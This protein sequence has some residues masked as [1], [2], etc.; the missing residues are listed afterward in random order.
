[1][2]TRLML[3]LGVI[4]LM[5]LAACQSSAKPDPPTQ[6]LL[7]P[8]DPLPSTWEISGSPRPMG[9][10][11]SIGFGDEDDSYINFKLKSSKY[12]ISSHYVLYYPSV[13]KAEAGYLKESR[14]G[15]NDNSIAIDKPWETPAELSYTSTYAEQFRVACTIN[16]VAGPKQV[17]VIMGQYGQYVTIFHSMIRSDT[18]SLREFN[19][20][21]RFLDEMMVRKLQL[22]R[23]S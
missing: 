16:N 10:S 23:S 3:W 7:L 2:G 4:S 12:I 19:D 18:M 13:R 17:C 9:P 6:E 22:D 11:T 1:M 20:V 21:V 8:L 5:T 14:S 15:F